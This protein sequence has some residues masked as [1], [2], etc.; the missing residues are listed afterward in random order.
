MVV[1]SSTAVDNVDE[2]LSYIALYNFDKAVEFGK[3]VLKETVF[4]SQNPFIGR[5]RTDLRGNYREWLI[6]DRKYK[7]YYRI[8]GRQAVKILIIR[9]T[10]RR[11]VTKFELLEADRI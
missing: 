3:L 7:I 6:D 5:K 2:I 1:W 11:P 4:L 8:L 10:R 9:H